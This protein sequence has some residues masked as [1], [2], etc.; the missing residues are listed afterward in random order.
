MV[1]TYKQEYHYP[2]SSW[3]PENQHKEPQKLL[4]WYGGPGLKIKTEQWNC[5]FHS[6]QIS[7]NTS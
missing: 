6:H 4:K 5:Q 7:S 3:Y 1:H 2:V